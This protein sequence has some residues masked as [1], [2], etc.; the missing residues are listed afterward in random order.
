MNNVNSEDQKLVSSCLSGKNEGLEELYRRFSGKM[1]GIC[2]RFTKNN[3]EAEDLLHDGF[4]K[5]LDNL[6]HFRNEGPLEGWMRR[7][8]VNTA[9]NL[10]RRKKSSGKFN[11]DIDEGYYLEAEGTDIVSGLSAEE[12]LGL[13]RDLPEGYRMVFNLYAIE[14]Y[15][16]Q[17]IALMLGISENTSKSQ[18]MK[19]RRYLQV[20]IKELYH[21][22][23]VR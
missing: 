2:L 4:I 16:H 7:L 17:E 9:I 1:F 13:V 10:F 5:V 12:L 22:S 8:M 23:S 11:A 21:E 15:K 3:M 14:G 6:K 20:R 18:F 19:A